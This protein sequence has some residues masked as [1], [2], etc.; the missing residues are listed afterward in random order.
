[1]NRKKINRNYHL[2]DSDLSTIAKSKIAFIRRDIDFFRDYGITVDNLIAL[3]NNVEAFINLPTD[4]E[5]KSNQALKTLAKKEKAVALCQA[6]E[7][8]MTIVAR[9]FK[10]SSAHYHSF[11]THH[12]IGQK[13][14]VLYITALVVVKRGMIYMED[15]SSFGLNLGIL[16]TITQ[17]NNEYAEL[18]IDQQESMADRKC[19]REIRIG[20]ANTIYTTLA[21]YMAVGLAIWET[22]STA[23]YNDYLIYNGTRNTIS[24]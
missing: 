23:R 19:Y 21:S 22:K 11:C 12:L 10:K 17:L 4:I 8:L 6:I 7:N 13:D 18:L 24:A 14:A 16:D 20:L 3:E 1:M 5:V 9:R 15:L 2:K